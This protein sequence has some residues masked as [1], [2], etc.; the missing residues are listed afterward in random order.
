MYEITHTND[1]AG[2]TKEVA[3]TRADFENAKNHLVN[4]LDFI[5]AGIYEENEI[6][7]AALRSK[8]KK[9]HEKLK[10]LGYSVTD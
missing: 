1:S 6:D 5:K 7:L 10:E 9:L 3:Q 8:T 4:A 2:F